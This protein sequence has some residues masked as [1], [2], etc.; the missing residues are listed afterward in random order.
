MREFLDQLR[1]CWFLKKDSEARLRVPPVARSYHLLRMCVAGC[2]YVVIARCAPQLRP[3]LTAVRASAEL[4][5]GKVPPGHAIKC[6]PVTFLLYSHIFVNSPSKLRNKL[7]RIV[8]LIETP[9]FRFGFDDT[10]LCWDRKT[11][12]HVPRT[13]IQLFENILRCIKRVYEIP[14]LK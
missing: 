5:G 8:L 13:E 10:S 14:V 4:A 6:R 7:T 3:L 1:N 11:T 12:F 9:K 2:S